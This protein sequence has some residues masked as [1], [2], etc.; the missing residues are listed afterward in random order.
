MRLYFIFVL[1]F[2]LGLSAQ[3][4]TSAFYKS[5]LDQIFDWEITDQSAFHIDTLSFNKDVGQF[6]LV[7]SNVFVLPSINN[8]QYGLIFSGNIYFSMTPPTSI[9]QDQLYRFIENKSCEKEFVRLFIFTADSAFI[10]QIKKQ[11]KTV[12]SASEKRDSD[13][14]LTDLLEKLGDDD[15][16]YFNSEML[17]VVLNNL[18][19]S[20]FYAHLSAGFLEK[21]FSFRISPFNDEEVTLSREKDIINMFHLSEEYQNKNNPP[22]IDKDQLKITHMNLDCRIENNM[23]FFASAEFDFRRRTKQDWYKLLLYSRLDVDSI[24]WDDGSKAEYFKGNENSHVWIKIAD[25]LKN[26]DEAGL[27]IFYHGDELLEKF[28]DWISIRSYHYWRPSY[29]GR[30]QYTTYDIKFRSPAIYDFICVGEQKQYEENGDYI[31][32]HWVVDKPTRNITFNLGRFITHEIDDDRVPPITVLLSRSGHRGPEIAFTFGSG[33]D[34]EKQVG[35]DILNSLVFFQYVFGPVNM[36]RYYVS[37]YPR[38]WSGEAFPGL[39]NL[40]WKTFQSTDV[41]GYD[42]ILRAHEV[43]HQ[44]WGINVDFETYHDQWLSE[45]M[46]EFCGLWYMQTI[47]EDK[48]KYMDVLEEYKDQIINNRKYILGDGQEAGPIWLGYRTS[49]SETEG[50]YGLIVYRK[51]A[52]VFQMLRV[53]MLNLQTMNEDAFTAMMKDVFNSHKNKKINTQSFKT[54]VEK[55]FGMP[56]DWFFDQW[57]YNVD[58]PMY[59]FAYSSAETNEGKYKVTL[60][61]KQE[62]VQNNFQMYVPLKIE[63]DDDRFARLRVQVNKPLTVIELPLLPAEPEAIIFNDLNGVLANVEEID[64][65]DID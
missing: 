13:R 54:I 32:S 39:I 30:N 44:W 5:T 64:W 3:E 4:P 49:S 50:D 2:T 42:E 6:K 24:K 46:S 57:I 11:P 43:A 28:D 15:L 18:N 23:D 27:T 1:F 61:I 26:H 35:A 52:W 12:A 40:G 20:Y 56:M 14:Y 33:K 16:Y 65:E 8:R 41:Y 19:N 7:N 58:I 21:D 53:M 9:E 10:N 36:N 38:F 48:S 25:S 34:M 62:N 45:G 55:H 17:N 22:V 31:F 59:K 47:S 60:K 29:G 37:E 63:F 51:S